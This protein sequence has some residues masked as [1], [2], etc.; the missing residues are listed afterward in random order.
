M[1]EIKRHLDLSTSGLFDAG[2]SRQELTRRHSTLD[3]TLWHTLH[4]EASRPTHAQRVFL[5]ITCLGAEAPG[6][7]EKVGELAHSCGA[8]LRLAYHS[9]RAPN[10]DQPLARLKQR[11]RHLGRLLDMA[12]ETVDV[13]LRS[14]DDL[15]QQMAACTLVCIAKSARTSRL[16]LRDRDVLGAVI[17][18]RLRPVLVL[19]PGRRQGASRTLVP[20]SLGPNSRALL[21]WAHALAPQAALELLHITQVPEQAALDPL[22]SAPSVMGQVLRRSWGA[23]HQRLRSLTEDFEGGA[24][25]L[26]QTVVHGVV[27]DAI[28]RHHIRR[29]HDLVVVGIRARKPWLQHLWPSLAEH[30]ARWL[31]CDVLVVPQGNAG[32][33]APCRSTGGPWTG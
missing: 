1:D 13:E 6:Y 7:L 28:G 4:A 3:E 9:G 25:G 22:A 32:S 12:V 16:G 31:N 21:D 17:D 27:E 14:L 33:G 29:R 20:V 18:L 11:A 2:R 5:V 15:R 19:A 23:L 10:L 24:Q 26:T 30:L 8:T